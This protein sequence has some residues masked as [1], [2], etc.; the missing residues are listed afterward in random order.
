[1]SCNINADVISAKNGS[2]VTINRVR[3]P[4]YDWELSPKTYVDIKVGATYVYVAPLHKDDI[5]LTI[6]ADE[7]AS[8]VAGVVSTGSQYIT[9]AKTFENALVAS[10]SPGS[11]NSVISKSYLDTRMANITFSS[12]MSRSGTDPI[13][14]SIANAAGTVPGVITGAAQT[15][16]GAFT[17]DGDIAQTGDYTVSGA[18]AFSG[19]TTAPTRDYTSPDGQVA[20]GNFV[21]ASTLGCGFDASNGWISGLKV[22]QTSTAKYV[23]QA[24]A[25]RFTNYFS[26]DPA[27]VAFPI[28]GAVVSHAQFAERTVDSSW[29]PDLVTFGVYIKNELDG[30]SIGKIYEFVGSFDSSLMYGDYIQVGTIT[31]EN[32]S[33]LS[34]AN[35]KSP[36]AERNDISQLEL[37][38]LI[39]PVNLGPNLIETHDDPSVDLSLKMAVGGHVWEYSANATTNPYNRNTLS[40][41][42][43][44]SK[45]ATT[46]LWHVWQ[47][48]ALEFV[49][50]TPTSAL[51]TANYNPG[52]EGTALAST[53]SGKWYNAPIIYNPATN[54]F[55]QQYATEQYNTEAE[56]LLKTHS[57]LRMYG[58]GNSRYYVCLGVI[59]YEGA[60]TDLSASTIGGG[61]FFNY[62]AAGG[63]GGGS[64]GGGGGI[65]TVPENYTA[66][67]SAAPCLTTGT[68]GYIS[69]QFPTYSDAIA[70]AYA[71]ATESRPTMVHFTAGYHQTS[72]PAELKPFVSLAS[73]SIGSTR[74]DINSGSNL[75]AGAEFATVDNARSSVLHM[76]IVNTSGINVD[77][78]SLGGTSK[79]SLFDFNTVEVEGGV[80]YVARVFDSNLADISGDTCRF[81]CCVFNSPSTIDAGNVIL[82]NVFF[83]IDTGGTSTAELVIQATNCIGDI[84]LVGSMLRDTTI[85]CASN[86]DLTVTVSSCFFQGTST[87]RL[88]QSGTGKLLFKINRGSIPFPTSTRFLFTPSALLEIFVYDEDEY[89]DN[90]VY[91]SAVGQ[92]T[93]R[94]TGRV[95]NEAVLTLPY[96]MGLCA[97]SVS[98]S[99][100]YVVNCQDAAIWPAGG[101]EDTTVAAYVNVQAPATTMR[102]IMS[103]T[104]GSKIELKD[105]SGNVLCAYGASITNPANDLKFESLSS[106]YIRVSANQP[107][108]YAN[109]GYMKATNS[110][111]ELVTASGGSIVY[112]TGHAATGLFTATGAGALIDLTGVG[113]LRNCTFSTASGGSIRHGPNFGA[114]ADVTGMLI[115]SGNGVIATA[116]AGTDYMLGTQNLTLNGDIVATGAITGTIASTISAAAVTL[117]KMANLP[118]MAVIANPTGAPAV[119]STVAMSSVNAATTLA[120]R[121]TAGNFYSNHISENYITV[122]STANV[123][124]SATHASYIRYTGGSATSYTLCATSGVEVGFAFHIVNLSTVVNATFSLFND[125][126]NSGGDVILYNG[127]YAHVIKEATN[128]WRIILNATAGLGANTLAS[129]DQYGNTSGVHLSDLYS[130]VTTTSLALTPTHAAYI[131]FNGGSAGAYTLP[132][133]TAVPAGF[134]FHIRNLCANNLTIT[135]ADGAA[136]TVVLSNGDYAHVVNDRVGTAWRPLIVTANTLGTTYTLVQRDGSGNSM[137]NH[138]SEAFSIVAGSF[139][140]PLTITDTA[141]IYYTGSTTG[142]TLPSTAVASVGFA[143]NLINAGSANISVVNHAGT[144][145]D[146]IIPGQIG[147]YIRS[148]YATF[149]S[150]YRMYNAAATANIP[151]VALGTI[152]AYS[153]LGNLGSSTGSITTVGVVTTATASTVVGRDAAANAVFNHAI[154]SYVPMTQGTALTASTGAFI[155]YSASSTQTGTL[156]ATAS[157]ATGFKYSIYNYG[158]NSL[159]LI[160]STGGGDVSTVPAPSCVDVIWDGSA[161][162]SMELLVSGSSPTIGTSLT[163]NTSTNGKT[164]ILNGETSTTDSAT[165]VNLISYNALTLASSTAFTVEYKVVCV[166]KSSIGNYGSFQGMIR[167]FYTTGGS[168]AVK[169][170]VISAISD[171]DSGCSNCRVQATNSTSSLVLQVGGQAAS[172]DILWTGQMTLVYHKVN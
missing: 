33:I 26:T 163:F 158:A 116:S 37:A 42:A 110:V 130:T 15:L 23:V 70:A 144:A 34:V 146:T 43:W 51:D 94:R 92:D 28:C 71:A 48:N 75:I 60:V 105:V 86:H 1:M 54:V 4:V 89:Q 46:P 137:V 17:F 138:L 19:T 125:T 35:I 82:N 10:T 5:T 119:P 2:Y 52:C 41:A 154:E 156:P 117:A 114:N 61:E 160:N 129:R 172:T 83:P 122:S 50:E 38:F 30:G 113:D 164:L 148:S 18:A 29:G 20:T 59:T 67:L 150:F 45:V 141:F 121:D 120:Y 168:V 88:L 64:A 143:C 65:A 123:Q 80:K 132:G 13:T 102:G 155:Y 161:W 106:A 66:W 165:W 104:Y 3:W 167:A 39:C 73:K 100:P 99:D 107:P 98:S 68:M 27:H 79:H 62:Q 170:P 91:L 36:L 24:G 14:V 101:T 115:G 159:V 162:K 53:T 63:V 31:Y 169:S 134:A 93:V 11:A 21:R 57:F 25:Y 128:Q 81:N 97:A 55:A 139:T 136:L 149:W 142:C 126:G 153:L 127:D 22:L 44:D 157:L 171:V 151:A 96:A 58:T 49:Y 140:S 135:N 74:F 72:G 84:Y 166:S 108:L 87:L 147:K 124:L 95:L 40:M 7:A 118:S 111:T 16:A 109:I 131:G 77:L 112:I 103:L 9:G 90:A 12:P 76:R 6:Y 47:N 8:G 78:Q 133:Y 56:A 85:N 32:G 152:A 69:D 145:V